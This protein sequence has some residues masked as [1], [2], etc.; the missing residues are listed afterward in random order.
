[1]RERMRM[2]RLGRAVA[3]GAV[4]WRA[5]VGL[6]YLAAYVA[7]DRISFLESYSTVGITP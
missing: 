5:F 1:M 2:M 4:D 7:L 6:G 3:A